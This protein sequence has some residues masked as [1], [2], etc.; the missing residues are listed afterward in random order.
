MS[1]V[2]CG[3]SERQHPLPAPATFRPRAAI[4]PRPEQSH[5]LRPERL[6]DGN[7]GAKITRSTLTTLPPP[8]VSRLRSPAGPCCRGRYSDR[9][10]PSPPPPS[11]ALVDSG[12]RCRRRR[13][14]WWCCCVVASAV[15]MSRCRRCPHPRSRVAR[16]YS[17]IRRSPSLSPLSH[18]TR[19]TRRRRLTPHPPR[20]HR[21][22]DSQVLS[23]PPAAAVSVSGVASQQVSP[24][25]AVVA[26]LL[27][28]FVVDTGPVSLWWAVL[29]RRCWSSLVSV[30]ALCR[31][32][33]SVLAEAVRYSFS[34]LC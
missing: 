23:S 26:G 8:L 21:D 27:S 11:L 3:W 29:R 15:S 6:A 20:S 9:C 10:S 2:S 16:D 34:V 31:R 5:W 32:C 19:N 4:R 33:W 7:P 22:T 30:V 17:S 12:V 1:S 14:W 13:R 28:L 18:R 24:G 25:V